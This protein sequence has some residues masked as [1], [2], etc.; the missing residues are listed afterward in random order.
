[1]I[2]SLSRKNKLK[3]KGNTDLLQEATRVSV[4]EGED[5]SS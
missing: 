5:G 3:K 2:T 1:M 4:E